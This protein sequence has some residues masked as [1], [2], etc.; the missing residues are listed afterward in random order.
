[1]D[2]RIGARIGRG[3]SW[4]RGLRGAVGVLAPLLL[5]ACTDDAVAPRPSAG[6]AISLT[7]D[8]GRRGVLA[9]AAP[10]VAS[11]GLR[12]NV[13]VMTT[14]YWDQQLTWDELRLLRDAGWTVVSHSMTHPDL[15]ALTPD[16]ARAEIRASRRTID[17]LGFHAGIFVVPYLL[18][19][20]AVLREVAEA[21]YDFARCC[22][23]DPAW[24]SDTLLDWPI[25][26]D[27]R[28]RLVGVDA[29]DYGAPSTYNFRTPEGRARLGSLLDDA[30]ARGKYVDLFFHEI[31]PADTADLRA[32]LALLGPH[33]GRM[34]RYDELR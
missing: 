5:L 26:R 8:D 6:G 25:A 29:T 12:A 7:F 2:L 1:M 9:H 19:D 18:H 17:S 24:S 3:A 30:M 14:R 33:R 32:T 27:A 28:H 11:L 22:A 21:G 23:H 16:S 31:T 15:T 34:V 20:A 10:I 13:A 4:R